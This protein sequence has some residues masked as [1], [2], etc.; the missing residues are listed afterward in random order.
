MVNYSEDY[1]LDKQIKIFQP[2]EGYR[3]STDAVLLAATMNK[4]CKNDRILDLGSGTGAVS[5]CLASKFSDKVSEIVGVEIQPELVELANKSAQANGFSN[6][7][8]INADIFASGLPFCSFNHV[9]TNPPYF[10][11]NMPTSPKKGKATA[12][13]FKQK[14]LPEWINICIKMIQP[15]GYLYMVNRA[16]ALD[17]ILNCIY[18][19]LGEITIFPIYSKDNQQAKRIVIRAKKDSKAPLKIMPGLVLH[20]ENG[21]YTES[22]EKILRGG[23]SL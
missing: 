21:A 1:L 12:H 9:Y 10:E 6:L 5:L 23:A 11:N 14:A 4:I 15:Q 16:E 8:Y 13:T 2:I 17:E 22:A 7:H 3:A 19:K 20:E 18:G